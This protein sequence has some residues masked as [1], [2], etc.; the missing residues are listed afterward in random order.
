[1][2]R[3]LSG[4]LAA[5]W[6]WLVG[7]SPTQVYHSARRQYVALDDAQYVAFLAGGDAA[8]PILTEAELREVLN[9]ANVRYL[10]EPLPL[11]E[12]VRPRSVRAR[13]RLQIAS[14]PTVNATGT[15]VPFDVELVDPLNM[16][17]AGNPDRI[18]IP[19]TGIYWGWA[20]VRW[21]ESTAGAGGTPNTG[22]RI[23]QLRIGASQV[24]ATTRLPPAPQDNTEFPVG[25]YFA[26]NEGDILRMI[27]EQRCG[28][29]MNAAARITI[30]REE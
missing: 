14:F 11:L 2:P 28:G 21:L 23:A 12:D 26:A 5:D 27:V 30:R 10:N 4:N 25:D 17:G 29:S 18:V 15:V 20:G 9:N 1:M 19:E 7:P 24:V 8:T 16:H 3:L 22:L 6:Y 13:C